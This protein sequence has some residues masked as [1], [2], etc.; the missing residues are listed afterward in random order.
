MRVSCFPC[1]GGAAAW[2]LHDRSL[3]RQLPRS[4]RAACVRLLSFVA[5]DAYTPLAREGYSPAPADIVNN[6]LAGVWISVCMLYA[7]DLGSSC[8][9]KERSEGIDFVF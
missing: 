2:S 6:E 3:P 5:V 9:H 4:D 1:A 8:Q 7:R